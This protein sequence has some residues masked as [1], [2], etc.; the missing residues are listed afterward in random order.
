LITFQFI[1]LIVGVENEII[2][3]LFAKVYPNP[4]SEVF[5]IELPDEILHQYPNL[6]LELYN[7]TGQSVVSNQLNHIQQSINV[8][9]LKSG[10]HFYKLFSKNNIVANGK[11]LIQ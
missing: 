4:A 11:L 7:T 10:M 1:P 6:Q 3:H 2:N 9:H 8:D 5:Y